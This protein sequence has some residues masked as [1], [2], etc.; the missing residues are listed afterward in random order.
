VSAIFQLDD[1][2]DAAAEVLVSRRRYGLFDEAGVGKTHPTIDAAMNL[3][4]GPVLVTAPAY[5]IPQWVK[6]IAQVNPYATVSDTFWC[7]GKD[8]RADALRADADFVVTSFNSWSAFDRKKPR[9]PILKSRKWTQCIVDESH[10]MRGRNNIWTK[11]MFAT[12]NVDSKNRDTG[13]WFLSGTPLV[14]NPGDLWTFLHMMDRDVFP[15]YW[16]FVEHWCVIQETPWDRIVGGLQPGMEDAFYELLSKYS[17]RRLCRNIPQ[18]SNLGEPVIEEI[19]VTLPPSVLTT[20]RKLKKEYT[21]S[22]PDLDEDVEYDYAG[23]VVAKARILTT[24]PP[25]NANPKLDTMMD[26]VDGL[27]AQPIIIFAWH[28]AVVT[29][30]VSRIKKRWSSRFC[31]PFT[32][33]TSSKAKVDTVAEWESTTNGILVAT[34]GAMAGGL[35]LQHSHRGI[36]VE[37]PDLP[38]DFEQTYKRMLRRGQTR[39]VVLTVIY[40]KDSPDVVIRRGQQ[41]KDMNIRKALKEWVYDDGS[42]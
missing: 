25:T 27:P 31:V 4:P 22:H 17:M 32:G 20:L 1:Y 37:E 21:L 3:E 16:S 9:Y 38:A 33:D 2:Q 26:V 36:Y 7:E 10:R 18:L 42:V 40:A 41:R 6:A 39:K 5:L 19:E 15:S 29:E 24:L 13:W 23:A 14:S 11:A 30:I 12:Q 34:I 35:N 8:A 28:K